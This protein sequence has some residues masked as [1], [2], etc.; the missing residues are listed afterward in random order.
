MISCIVTLYNKKEYFESCINSIIENL[1]T[2]HGG[3][4]IIIVDDQSTDGS[5][6]IAEKYKRYYPKLIKLIVNEK[7]R[8]AGFSRQVGIDNAV[9]D[10]ISFIDAD[11]FID[12]DFFV[13]MENEALE[14]G[15][16]MVYGEY[17]PLFD[18]GNNIKTANH[19]A[20]TILDDMEDASLNMAKYKLQFLN[21]SLTKRSLYQSGVK[22]CPS[23][24]IE[25]TPTA[26]CLI[27]KA[28]RIYLTSYCGYNYNQIDTSLIHTHKDIDMC[29]Y[30]HYNMIW[31]IENVKND[32][33][34]LSLKLK[35]KYKNDIYYSCCLYRI[36][37]NDFANV[38]TN[39]WNDIKEYYS[40]DEAKMLERKEYAT[41]NMSKVVRG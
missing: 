20:N 35:E 27:N 19:Y 36:D 9:G 5:L 29:M 7:N 16:D 30:L 18:Y 6:L 21:I 3:L 15:S 26:L 14:H 8:G 24:F 40:L 39:M 13:T 22:Y 11:D 32:N 31:A 37:A 12:E 17:L 4:E 33:F 1:K 23:R 25:D 34:E 41:K 28:K 38:D 2:Y 10:W